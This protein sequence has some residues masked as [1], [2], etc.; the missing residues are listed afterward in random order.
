MYFRAA[1][2]RQRHRQEPERR[3]QRGHQHGTEPR[4]RAIDDRLLQRLPLLTQLVD[5]GDHHETIQHG[6]TG[7]GDETDGRGDGERDAARPEQEHAA[8]QRQRHAGKHEQRVAHAAER[9]EQQPE[10][11][12]QRHR[13][14]ELQALA[15][16]DQLLELPAPRRPVPGGNRHAVANALLGVGDERADVAATDIGGDHDAPLAVFAAHLARPRRDLEIRD[17]PERDE[18]AADR[19][20]GHRVTARGT[21]SPGQWHRDPLHLLDVRSPGVGQPDQDVEPAI[22]LEHLPGRLAADRHLDHVL[23]IG[24]VEAQARHLRPLQVNGEQRQAGGLFD[25]GVGRSRDRRQDGLD[26][27]PDIRQH[28]HVVTKYFHG[29]VAADAGDQL[30][31]AHLNR[32]DELV[33]VPG[34]QRQFLLQL[35]DELRLGAIGIWPGVAR[36]EHDIGVRDAGR[37]RI[38][39]DI[40]GADLR[41]HVVHFGVGL[42]RALERVLHFDGGRQAGT[43]NPQR[44][45]EEIAFIEA[46][47]KLAAEA[48]GHRAGHQHQRAGDGDGRSPVAH[49]GRQ[50][51]PVGALGPS[52]DHAFLLGDA[53]GHEQRH[54]RRHERDRQNHRAE[55]RREHGERHRVEHLAL[56]A[57]E[58]QDGQ[59]HDHDDQL[60]E[61]RGAPHFRGCREHRLE[62]LGP[63]QQ[64]AE[65]VLALAEPA[66]AVLD[67]DDGAV[68][69]DAEI[70]RAQ[71]QQIAADAPF[72][73]ARDGEQ[74]R[75]RNDTRRDQR[76]TDVSQEHEQDDDDQERADHEV[77][78]DG[79]DRGVDQRGAI[80]DGLGNHS[81]REGPVHLLHL[82]RDTLRH[83][84]A[85]LAHQHQDG[86]EHHFLA[87]FGRRA[88]PQFIA[89]DHV[90]HRAQVH[91]RP[92]VRADDDAS[93]ILDVF[94]LPRGSDQ[95]LFAAALDV[96]RADVGVVA[97]QRV[98]NVPERQPVGDQL[99]RIGRHMKLL[100]VAADAVDIGHAGHGLQLRPDDPVLD[101]PQV[102]RRIGL[103]LRRLR[104]RLALDG[105][106]E[107]LAKPRGDRSHGRLDA[108]RQA[109]LDLLDALGNELS[110]EIDIGAVLEDDRH[111][112][113]AIARNGPGLFQPRQAGHNR[114]DQVGDALLGLERRVPGRFGVDL[115]LH[116]GDVRHRIDRQPRV[117]VEA[118]RGGGHRRDHHEP[119]VPNREME[120]AFKH[121]GRPQ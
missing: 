91:R 25:L 110:R 68:D 36:L 31:E 83:D 60:A 5:E 111:L 121:G 113:Q 26:P 81:G 27:G 8:G 84:P 2:G 32:L 28:R 43:R 11:Q 19:H 109:A 98:E 115:D 15:R 74:H 39:R 93:D 117:V 53:P 45:D 70:E 92:L 112:R 57:G 18:A 6:D 10:N 116:V 71:A 108:R 49:R 16:R 23:H 3:D 94:H 88:G 67:D 13:H 1:A 63:G 20:G 104:A 97:S 54:R 80:V 69:D 118:E 86:A 52:D 65:P 51:R 82:R 7:Q 21:R 41:E 85:V 56:D 62:P 48:H 29:H 58:G 22:A 114:L 59:I 55:Q 42:E 79:A 37:H 103:S 66:H 4:D 90:G 75:Q 96:A 30:V 40:R 89:E 100:R 33:I 105:P 102:H 107:D 87:V 38:G 106:E 50:G 119:P 12:E 46:R 34:N 77:V 9:H 64:T 24:H 101:R 44:M 73:H 61:H 99:V 17:R 120:N 72:D 76:G 35:L 47:E 14:D 78:A 95:V